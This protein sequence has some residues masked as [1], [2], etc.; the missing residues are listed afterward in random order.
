M[1]KLQKWRESA[2]LAHNVDRHAHLH[3]IGVMDLVGN[4]GFCPEIRYNFI[5]YVLPSQSH[6]KKQRVRCNRKKVRRGKKGAFEGKNIFCKRYG[7]EKNDTAPGTRR[8]CLR[9]R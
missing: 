5:R 4:L 7:L 3:N 9:R 1:P 6:C 2:A 8:Y